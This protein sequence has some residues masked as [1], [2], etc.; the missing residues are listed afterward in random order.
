MM[1]EITIKFDNYIYNDSEIEKYLTSLKG[2]LEVKS[3]SK[4]ETIYIKYDSNKISL[5]VLKLEV[6]AFLNLLKFPAIIAFNKHSKNKTIKRTLTIKYPC[7]EYCLNNMIE[8]LFLLDGIASAFIDD[9]IY[10]NESVK[11]FIEYDNTLI[12]EKEITNIEIKLNN[13][14]ELIKRS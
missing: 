9:Y 12:N 1:K 7:C 3:T 8:E 6:L 10:I 11:L 14:E 4:E 2:I 5:K 13:R